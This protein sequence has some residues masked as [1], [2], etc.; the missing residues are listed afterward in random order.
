MLQNALFSTPKVSISFEDAMC[1]WAFVWGE[2]WKSWKSRMKVNSKW[3]INP[4]L[5]DEDTFIT[6]INFKFLT[7]NETNIFKLFKITR[8]NIIP[9]R[10]HP[11][12]RMRIHHVW[13]FTQSPHHRINIIQTQIHPQNKRE[14]TIENN[15]F[16]NISFL[17]LLHIQKDLRVPWLHKHLQNNTSL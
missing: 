2:T 10:F 13:T 3:M 9:N 14:F 4:K 5:V 6:F 7:R 17:T 8:L 11:R 12:M 15:E 16:C 1:D